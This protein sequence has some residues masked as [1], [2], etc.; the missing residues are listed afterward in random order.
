MKLES[1]HEPVTGQVNVP[2]R[3]VRED[4]DA[5]PVFEVPE[6]Y[7]L[8]WYEEGDAV[9]WMRIHQTCEGYAKLSPSLFEDQYGAD[10]STLSE[11]IAFLCREDGLAVSTNTAWMSDWKGGNWGRVHWVATDRQEQGKGLSKPLRTQICHRLRDLGH[12]CAYLTTNTLR[13]RA[14]SLYADF[15]FKAYWETEKEE[16]AWSE[17]RE[18]LREIGREV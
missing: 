5:I 8:R 3:M 14:I 2:V 4:L 11:R 16:A 9:H 18:K 15:G 17:L 12:A 6:G 7:S 10:V 13:V 1:K